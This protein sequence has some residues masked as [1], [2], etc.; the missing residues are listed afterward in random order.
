MGVIY[1]TI[2]VAIIWAFRSWRLDRKNQKNGERDENNSLFAD[3]YADKVIQ[4]ATKNKPS[5]SQ[6]KQAKNGENWIYVVIAVVI[7]VLVFGLIGNFISQKQQSDKAKQMTNDVNY[8]RSIAAQYGQQGTDAF[9]N[10]YY[11]CVNRSDW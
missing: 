9:S 8:C 6:K 11:A 1:F 5:V 4:D 10:A 7:A 3:N 2:S